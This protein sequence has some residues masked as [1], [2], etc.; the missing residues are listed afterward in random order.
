MAAMAMARTRLRPAFWFLDDAQRSHHH[1]TRA[2]GDFTVPAGVLTR[3]DRAQ[4]AVM[5]FP[6]IPATVFTP[7]EDKTPADSPAWA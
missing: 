7:P 1:A 5:R 6:A 4:I 3:Q 2:V